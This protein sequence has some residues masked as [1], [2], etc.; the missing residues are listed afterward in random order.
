MIYADA[1]TILYGE[2]DYFVK[3][4]SDSSK[5]LSE[6]DIIQMFELV[7]DNKFAMIGVHVF[8]QRVSIPMCTN[9]APLFAYLFLYS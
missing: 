5:Y 1:N 6:T 3:N 9:C 8:P 4:Y 7:I 2:K